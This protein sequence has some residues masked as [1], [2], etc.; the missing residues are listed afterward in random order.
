MANFY[1]G[2]GYGFTYATGLMKKDPVLPISIDEIIEGDFFMEDNEVPYGDLV[3]D[4]VESLE[5][6]DTLT[7]VYPNQ[8]ALYILDEWAEDYNIPA[9]QRE[10]L[11]TKDGIKETYTYFTNADEEDWAWLM[12]AKIDSYDE[13]GRAVPRIDKSQSPV[14]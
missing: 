4:H 10:E 2:L 8:E 14:I 3:Q 6:G 9:N 7:V 1:L 11:W 12:S 5:D 13:D